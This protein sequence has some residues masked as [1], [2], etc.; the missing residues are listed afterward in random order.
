MEES[1]KEFCIT[2]RIEDE[3]LTEI[4]GGILEQS[5][6]RISGAIPGGILRVMAGEFPAR[7]RRIE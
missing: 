5:S 7:V 1:L 4:H 3:I 6:K 2:V